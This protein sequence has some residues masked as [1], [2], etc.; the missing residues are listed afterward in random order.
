MKCFITGIEGFA[1]HHLANHLLAQGCEVSGSFFDGSRTSGLPSS[2]ALHEL[3]LQDFETMSLAVA[4]IRPD[5]IYHLAA[6]SSDALSFRNPK[7]TFDI[8]I[9]GLVNLLESVR[10]AGI[11]P[12]IVMVSSCEVYGPVAQD[13][14]IKEAQGYNPISPYA[15]SKVAQEVIGLQYHRSFGLDVLIAR[16]FPHVGPGQAPVFALPGFAKQIAEIARG[17]KPPVIKVGNLQSRRDLSDVR[18]VVEAYLLL[19]RKG[20]AGE[21][22]N[23]CS[24]SVFSIEQALNKMLAFSGKNIK[25]EVD[26]ARFRPSDVPILWGDNGKIRSA[27]GWTPRRS[28]ED[29]LKELLDSWM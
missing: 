5:H 16:P 14:P 13:A 26:P 27:T 23:I 3:D 7:K 4:K 28:I 15:A 29:A 12:R 8:N 18:D 10:V 11:R 19:A 9:G 21:A 17:E 6:Q 24:G 2:C 20:T 22:Y 1:G 25:I